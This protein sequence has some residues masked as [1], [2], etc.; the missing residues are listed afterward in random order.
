ME[1]FIVFV[2]GIALTILMITT[3]NGFDG[4]FD[5]K[6]RHQF[7]NDSDY[8]EHYELT[9]K[10]NRIF[11]NALGVVM[12]SCIIHWVWLFISFVRVHGWA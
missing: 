7:A 8:D 10:K 5:H 3:S 12:L 9:N 2:F 4:M 11:K 1:L 6:P